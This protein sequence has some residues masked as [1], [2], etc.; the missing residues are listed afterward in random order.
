[1]KATLEFDLSDSDD[2]VSFDDWYYSR[3][4]MNALDEVRH[5]LR[6]QWKHRDLSG[7][8]ADAL[9]DEIWEHFHDLAGF[10]LEAME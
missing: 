3:N 7:M 1:M 4:A 10:V 8:T 2:R 6:S 9:I 5:Y